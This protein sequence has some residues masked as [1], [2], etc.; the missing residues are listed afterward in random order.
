MITGLESPQA[1]AFCEQIRARRELTAEREPEAHKIAVRPG[2]LVRVGTAREWADITVVDDVGH[3]TVELL[4]GAAA[5]MV[6]EPAPS[7]PPRSALVRV[8][9]VAVIA[10]MVFELI[11]AALLVLGMR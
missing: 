9:W 4:P 1:I 2:D 11:A 5:S 10:L 6:A 8:M 3:I 7:A